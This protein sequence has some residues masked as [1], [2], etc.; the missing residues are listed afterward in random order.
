MFSSKVWAPTALGLLLPLSSLIAQNASE[1]QFI[2]KWEFG[3][4]SGLG[5]NMSHFKEVGNTTYLYPDGQITGANY[6]GGFATRN[7]NRRWSLRT[8]LSAVRGTEE[9]ALSLGIYPRYHLTKWLGLEAGLEARNMLDIGEKNQSKLWLGTALSW[10]GM[11]LNLRYSPSFMPKTNFLQQNWQHS[12]QVGLS[13]NLA[14]V[15]KVLSSKN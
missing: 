3:L 13:L 7:F 2:P 5:F 4:R 1:A 11:E 9:T 8:E 12:F 10:K 14:R 15:G 6:L